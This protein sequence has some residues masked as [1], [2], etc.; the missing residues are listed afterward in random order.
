MKNLKQIIAR[1]G[2]LPEMVAAALSGKSQRAWVV[3]VVKR[4]GMPIGA[5]VF[6]AIGLYCMYPFFSL[7][8]F[9]WL[10]PLV[11]PAAIGADVALRR[12]TG[13]VTVAVG[14]LRIQINPRDPRYR[15]LLLFM[16]SLLLNVAMLFDFR[17]YHANDYNTFCGRVPFS[18]AMGFFYGARCLVEHGAVDAWA[19]RRPLAS[20]FYAV[21]L[22]LTGGSLSAVIFITCLLFGY[23]VYRFAKIISDSFGFSAAM[24]LVLFISFYHYPHIAAPMTEN[25]G[26]IFGCFSA[27]LLWQG[28]VHNSPKRYYAGLFMLGLGMAIRAGAL[29]VLPLTALFGG[30]LFGAAKRRI[31]AVTCWCLVAGGTPFLINSTVARIVAPRESWMLNGNLSYTLYGLVNGDKEWQYIRTTHPELFDGSLSDGEISR[32]IYRY[33]L[34]DF[35]S[36]PFRAFRAVGNIYLHAGRKLFKIC[37]PFDFI[38]AGQVFAIPWLIALLSP[39]IFGWKRREMQ[40]ILLCLVIVTGVLASWPV[41]KTAGYRAIAVTV[42]LTCVLA[43]AGIGIL[44][45]LL[46]PEGGYDSG[47]VVAGPVGRGDLHVS[48]ILVLMLLAGPFFLKV[49]CPEN[50]YLSVRTGGDSTTLVFRIFRG[51]SL[52]I[53]PDGTV[54]KGRS[55]PVG[56]YRTANGIRSDQPEF[57]LLK[58]GDCLYSAVYNLADPSRPAYY[59]AVDRDI[60]QYAG[61]IARCRIEKTGALWFGKNVSIIGKK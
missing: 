17:T 44:A 35:K 41:V 47:S 22:K 55:V 19:A 11:I 5:G 25:V 26:L 48:A 46:K 58:P 3:H 4:Y 7:C 39:L 59:L 23:S 42:P 20:C 53:A 27:A 57:N 9:K 37:M 61:S 40:G 18:D 52:L 49:T 33:T 28:V 13:A 45:G 21:A 29:F 50:P 34:Q 24:L 31:L 2:D 32:R 30:I 54:A 15:Y 36:N 6:V 1:P 14:P 10:L 51:A 43:A 16:A 12:G 38:V 56:L 8:H 60:E